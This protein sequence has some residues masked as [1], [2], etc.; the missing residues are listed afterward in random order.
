MA[1]LA[2]CVVATRTL[3][4]TDAAFNRSGRAASKSDN[5]AFD[6]AWYAQALMKMIGYDIADFAVPLR[7]PAVEALRDFQKTIGRT[8]TG[9]VDAEIVDRLLDAARGAQR[10]GRSLKKNLLDANSDISDVTF[11][12]A[13]RAVPERTFAEELEQGPDDRRLL[14]LATILSA[15][16]H[17]CSL[18][19]RGARLVSE[20]S[21][22]QVEC[23]EG[24]FQLILSDD[25][26][27]VVVVTR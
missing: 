24:R 25:G 23:A 11:A 22:W 27:T 12:S 2:A 3:C 7:R 13:L 16:G 9:K 10:L 4:W 17:A 20:E 26:D 6:R 21:G 18:P 19:A 5:I 14:A 15:R 1:A 8:P